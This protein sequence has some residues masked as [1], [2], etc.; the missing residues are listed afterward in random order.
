[1]GVFSGK[2]MGGRDLES[3]LKAS[4]DGGG[5]YKQEAGLPEI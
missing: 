2:E 4:R 1:M 5:G 3:I